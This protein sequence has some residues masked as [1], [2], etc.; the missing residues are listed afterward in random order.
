MIAMYLIGTPIFLLFSSTF[1][2]NFLFRTC[3]INQVL[4][5]IKNSKEQIDKYLEWI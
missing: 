1:L 4:K 5:Y 3:L 2:N